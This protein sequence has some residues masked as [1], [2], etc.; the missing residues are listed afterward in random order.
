MKTFGEVFDSANACTTK[1]EAQAWLKKEIERHSVEYKYTPEESEKIIKANLGYFAGY[2]DEA[3][4]VK[5]ETLFG[6]QHPIF[7]SVSRKW[8]PDEIFKKGVELG[9]KAR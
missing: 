4:R 8:T 6:A 1:E 9:Q 3:T 5:I 2:Y 7:G